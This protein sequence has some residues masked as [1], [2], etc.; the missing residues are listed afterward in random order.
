MLIDSKRK[1][2]DLLKGLTTISNT[3][4]LGENIKNLESVNAIKAGIERNGFISGNTF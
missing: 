1:G 3:E 2:I 4:N